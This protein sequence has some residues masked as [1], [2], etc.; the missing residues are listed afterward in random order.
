MR[1]ITVTGSGQSRVPPDCAVVRVAAVHRAAAVADALAGADTAARSVA[2]VAARHT[3]AARTAS[4]GLAVWPAH[5]DQGRASSYS[6]RH[7]LTIGCSDLESAGALLTELAEVVGDRLEIEGVSLDVADPAAGLRDARSAAYDDAVV[8]ATHLAA[9][10]GAGLGDVQAIT[11]G[12]WSSGPTR[13]VPVAAKA[14]S[15]SP[16][17]TTLDASVTVTFQLL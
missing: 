5:D 8:R 16:G 6:A 10:A 9:L 12:G 17:E 1:T 3:D 11:E 13:A 2:T 4:T 14:V 7:S 15:F